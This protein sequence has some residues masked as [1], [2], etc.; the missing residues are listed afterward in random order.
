MKNYQD[1][2]WIGRMVIGKET[3]KTLS[4]LMKSQEEMPKE[5]VS[6][7]FSFPCLY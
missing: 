7:V 1:L 6:A 4:M 3:D 2:N 5:L